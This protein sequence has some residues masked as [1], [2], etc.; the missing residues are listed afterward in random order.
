MA[1]GKRSRQRQQALWVQTAAL[2][3]P[4]HPFYKRLNK[5]FD[6]H[7]FDEFVEDRCTQFYAEQIGRPSLPP[8]V[9]CS[10]PVIG[11]LVA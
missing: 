2:K 6:Q 4:S 5:I 9:Y 3:A 8:A 7:S 10:G 11:G 1:M